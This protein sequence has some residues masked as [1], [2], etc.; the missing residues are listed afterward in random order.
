MYNGTELTPEL[1]EEIIKNLVITLSSLEPENVRVA[2]KLGQVFKEDLDPYFKGGFQNFVN[3][4][5]HYL[6]IELCSNDP[7]EEI[8][9]NLCFWDLKLQSK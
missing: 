3:M 7:E 9:T 2:I 8:D 4:Y 5:P 1:K 6:K